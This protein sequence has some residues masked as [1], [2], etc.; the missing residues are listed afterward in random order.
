[1]NFSANQVYAC[2]R[3]RVV[4]AAIIDARRNMAAVLESRFGSNFPGTG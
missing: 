4:I 1:M 2:E 3:K